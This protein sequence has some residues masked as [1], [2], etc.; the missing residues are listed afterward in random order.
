MPKII[1]IAVTGGPGAGKSSGLAKIEEYFSKL[2]WRVIVVGETA[3]EMILGGA[4]P[5]IGTHKDFHELLI[6]LQIH[7]EKVYF[8]FASRLNEDVLIVCDR[9]CADAKAF[10]NEDEWLQVQAYI[11]VNEVVLRDGY[12]AVFHLVTAANGAEQ[13]YMLENNKARTET[14]EQAILQ[15]NKLISAWTGHPHLRVID[16]RAGF[17]EKI[18]RLI[19]EIASFLGEPE[20]M[21]IERKFLIKYPNI[22][23][24]EENPNCAK[25]DIIQTY[26][27]T[28]CNGAEKRLRQ[29]GIDGHYVFTE[30]TKK[31]ITDTKRIETERRLTEKEYIHLLMNADSRLKPIRKARYCLS[32]KNQYLEI[33][34][35][36]FWDR[37]AI[38]EIEL[39]CEAQ[40]IVFPDFIEV[41]RELTDDK[42]YKNRS[43]ALEIPEQEAAC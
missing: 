23:L 26:L 22:D 18:G 33:D 17:D 15:D 11:D 39:S 41:I 27:S 6:V 21:E 13:F 35:Y 34:V 4:T 1:K 12:D 32:H 40:E 28:D 42:R 19:G 16:N 14:V 5:W 30:T 36:P 24:L 20:P 2:G 38:L 37:Q 9:G 43:L 10:L 25:V 7:K 31:E 29:R 8:E 3:A